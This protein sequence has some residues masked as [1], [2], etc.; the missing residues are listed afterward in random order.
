[1]PDRHFSRELEAALP[2]LRNFARSLTRDYEQA[3]DLVQETMLKA[4][5]ARASFQA[6][7]SFSAWTMTILKNVYLSQRRRAR[8]QA[9][10]SDA[11][12]AKLAAPAGEQEQRVHV[13]DLV[14]ALD[15]LSPEQREAVLLVAVDVRSYD[16]AARFAGVPVGTLKSR[17]SRAR[18][19]LHALMDREGPL[20]Q[21]A[22]Y[23]TSKATRKVSRLLPH[24]S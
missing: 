9:D 23:V 22:I 13:A 6:G 16:E 5:A 19:A 2:R 3:D 14:R 7:T 4:W 21:Q 20:A 1:M 17:V 15:K 24:L 10:W 8:F 12:A 11:L 18:Q